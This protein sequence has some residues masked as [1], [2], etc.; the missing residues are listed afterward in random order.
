MCKHVWTRMRKNSITKRI[1]S[2]KVCAN[3]RNTEKSLL[4]KNRL[5]YDTN[6][7][8]GCRGGKSMLF[9]DIVKERLNSLGMTFDDLVEISMLDK[10]LC[11][12][13]CENRISPKDLDEFDLNV[14]S[15]ALYCASDY[16]ISETARN[17]DVVFRS[18]NRGDDPHQSNLIKA[19]LQ[20]FMRDLL[21]VKGCE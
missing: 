9:G 12:K 11:E 18:C 16:F 8:K 14:L 15:N 1:S 3:F 5:C 13:I 21:F 4:F 2:K 10:D 20:S 19:K 17:K 6:R 7:Y